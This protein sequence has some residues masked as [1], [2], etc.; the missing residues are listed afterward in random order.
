MHAVDIN[1]KKETI[2]VQSNSSTMRHKRWTTDL[3]QS[4]KKF[5][6]MCSLSLFYDIQ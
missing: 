6:F 2:L 4:K 5:I 3:I 1:R